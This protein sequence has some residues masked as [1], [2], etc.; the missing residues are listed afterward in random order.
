MA[1]F[2][3]KT[4]AARARRAYRRNYLKRKRM[5]MRSNRIRYNRRLRPSF[6]SVC[7]RVAVTSSL[8]PTAG[9]LNG[10]YQYIR[11]SLDSG[12][13]QFN[14]TGDRLTGLTNLS[15]YTALFE[16]FRI[17]AIKFEF[18]PRF[19]DLNQQQNVAATDTT[20]RNPPLVYINRDDHHNG[21]LTGTWDRAFFNVLMEHGKG[22]IIRADRPFSVY[23]RKPSVQEDVV[24]G[25]QRYVRSP[26]L[27]LNANGT[28]TAHRGIHM[29]IYNT[30]FDTASF[31]VL[32]V[33]ITYYLQFRNPK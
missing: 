2:T 18:R 7:R 26:W 28:A 12:I 16:Q 13:A 10:F 15:E 4:V 9:S 20:I 17:N 30:T 29:F 24:S 22:K 14:A 31:P 8:T 32:D 1:R 19:Q 27:D 33:Y 11:C 3:R 21:S 5:G 25:A 23:M 6:L